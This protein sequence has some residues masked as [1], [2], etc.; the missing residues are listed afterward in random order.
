MPSEGQQIDLRK[1]VTGL[2]GG[3]AVGLRGAIHD[4]AI[5]QEDVD[6]EPAAGRS[7]PGR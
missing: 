3:T 2:L 7:A 4:V 1:G 6:S 5:A